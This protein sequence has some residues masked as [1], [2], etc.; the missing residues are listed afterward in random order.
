[1]AAHS[2]SKVQT[3]NKAKR[4]TKAAARIMAVAGTPL[5]AVVV[6]AVVVVPTMAS[7]YLDG[8]A[9]SQQRNSGSA[10]NTIQ[11]KQTSN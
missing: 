11:T 1:M 8:K 3:P 2:G 5:T 10:Q 9:H 4:G 6:V 7:A